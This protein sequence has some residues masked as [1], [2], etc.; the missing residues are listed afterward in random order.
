MAISQNRVTHLIEELHREF[1]VFGS[2]KVIDFEDQSVLVQKGSH[3]HHTLHS[4]RF[5]V[6]NERLVYRRKRRTI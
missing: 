3:Y 6:V 4:Y 1:P 2:I 5:R